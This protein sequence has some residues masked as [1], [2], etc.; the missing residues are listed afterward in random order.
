M[1]RFRSFHGVWRLNIINCGQVWM[2]LRLCVLGL[3]PT[4]KVIGSAGPHS[5][6]LFTLYC[7]LHTIA[8]RNLPKYT[9]IYL[10]AEVTEGLKI[11]TSLVSFHRPCISLFQTFPSSTCYVLSILPLGRCSEF[12]QRICNTKRLQGRYI[13]PTEP[14]TS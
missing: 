14:A 5:V 3:L 12:W 13:I 2:A 11:P 9:I 4:I 7:T 6:C 8:I 1:R 10:S